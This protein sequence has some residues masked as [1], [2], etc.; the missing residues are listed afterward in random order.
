MLMVVHRCII[1]EKVNNMNEYI[2]KYIGHS[3]YKWFGTL[4]FIR[5]IEWR[6]MLDWLEPKE[7][8][9]ILDIAC[10]GER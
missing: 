5:Q 6:N 8:E 2:K 9:K 1:A 4:N 3:I 7:G 10:G